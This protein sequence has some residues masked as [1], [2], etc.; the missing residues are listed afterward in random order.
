MLKFP[1]KENCRNTHSDLSI[2]LYFR[3]LRHQVNKV[4]TVSLPNGLSLEIWNHSRLIA[5]DTVKVNLMVKIRIEMKPEYF[6]NPEQYEI[7]RNVFGSE[8]FYEYGKERTFVDKSL[9]DA[10]FGRL[11]EEFKENSLDYISRPDF[12]ARFANSRFIEIQKNPYKYQQNRKIA[13]NVQKD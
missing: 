1:C 13:P 12:A 7:T 6:Q 4:D 10:V 2:V 8:V 9:K 5:A 11:L 3:R